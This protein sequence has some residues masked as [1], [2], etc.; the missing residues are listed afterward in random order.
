MSDVIER[1]LVE[2]DMVDDTLLRDFLAELEEAATAVRPLPSA[3]LAALLVPAPRRS[4]GGRR[5]V[6]I[7]T[8]IVVGTIG[9]GATAAAAS[10]EVRDAT[11]RAIEAVVGAL[12]PSA[13]TVPGTVSTSAPD[14]PIKPRPGQTSNTGHP[15]P[16]NHPGNTDHPG[17]TNHPE[18]SD[19]PGKGS[20]QGNSNPN[21]PSGSPHPGNGSK[22][23]P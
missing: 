23:Q 18:P 22:G 14:S 12:L 6:I 9:A 13:P 15:N 11:G 2:A 10:P 19:H 1:L 5:R 3:E 4:A 16:T 21:S 17:N 7:T 8:M 20:T